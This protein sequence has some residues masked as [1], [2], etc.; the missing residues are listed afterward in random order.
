MNNQKI[1]L[2]KRVCKYGNEEILYLTK[3]EAAFEPLQDAF[4]KKNPCRKC[5]KLKYDS[6]SIETPE[7]DDELFALWRDNDEY[8]FLQQDEDLLLAK[9]SHLNRLLTAF[10]DENFPSEKKIVVV[11][12]LCVL[13]FDNLK[14]PKETYTDEQNAQM[15][16]NK[17][18]LLPKLQK[19]R[20][21]IIAYQ[22]CIWDYVW[23]EIKKV[24]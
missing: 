6:M 20:E 12:A 8:Y 3:E 10:D 23:K 15:Q 5:G 21:K 2:L 1:Y 4:V 18:I 11:N 19:R 16:E 13:L 24:L 9:M 14:L 22:D 17:A 7:I